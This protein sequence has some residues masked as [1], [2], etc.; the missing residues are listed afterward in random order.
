[1]PGGGITAFNFM[2]RMWLG[3]RAAWLLTSL[4]ASTTNGLEL[5]T[6]FTSTNSVL[7]DSLSKLAPCVFMK[8]ESMFLADRIC[9]SHTPPMWLANGG[10]LFHWIQSALFCNRIPQLSSD[11]PPSN[12]R[13]A[14]SLSLSLCSHKI[15]TSNFSYIATPT[16][17]SSECQY[18]RVCVHSF[19]HFNMDGTTCQAR[20]ESPISFQC[21]SSFFDE[22]WTKYVHTTMNKWGLF[23]QSVMW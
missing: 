14:L 10:F 13:L 9:L 4:L 2:V 19:D 7:S 22:K 15:V 20:E 21:I 16:N 6:P 17:K 3:D 5:A 1:M 11:W 18:K 12:I 8:G 23:F